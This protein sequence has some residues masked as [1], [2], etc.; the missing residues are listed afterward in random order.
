MTMASSNTP[1]PVD[2]RFNEYES[3]LKRQ[4]STTSKVWDEMTK[5][6]CENKNELKAQCNHCKTIFSAKSSSGTSHL[7]HHLNRCLKKFDADECRQAISTFLVC[8]K[9][10]FRTVEEPGFRYMMR[11]VS[12]NFKNISRHTAARDVLMYYAKERDHVK[13]EL[14]RASGLIC[15]TSDNWNSEHTNDEYICITAHWVDKDWNLQKRIIRFRAL[16][17][18]YDGLNIADELVL[19]LSQWVIDKKN[20]SITLDNASY[21]DVMVSCLKNYFRAN[22]A[23]LCDGAFFQ[24]RCCAHILNLIIKAGLELANDV[25]G[26][27]RKRFYDATDKSFHL[28]VTKKL[29]QDVCERW[30]S[31]YLMLESSLYYKDVLDYWGQRDKDYQMFSLSNEEWRNIAILCKFLKVFYDVTCIFSGSNYPKGNLYFKGVRKVHKV[32]LDTVK[33]P[34][35]FLTPMVKQMQEKFNKYWAEYSL[36]LSCAAILDP[37][38]KL[39]YVQYYFKTI[40]GIHASDFVETILSNLRLLFDE[41]VKKSK[42]TSSSLAES[43]NVSDKNPVDSGLD[44]HNVNS[45]NFGGYFD[46]SDDYKWYLDESSTRTEKSQLDI[47]L[48]EPELE[49]NSQIDVLDYWSKSLVRYNELSLL[50]RDLLAIPISNV[51]SESAFSMDK[52]VITPLKSSL[53]PKTVQAVVCLDDWMRAKGFSTTN[54]Y[55]HFIVKLVAKRTIRTMR[56][57]RMMF[58]RLLFRIFP[59]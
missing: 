3:A 43:S 54:Y 41:Y 20:F 16:F 45:A 22:R 56:T 24:I 55:S 27:R 46:E 14:A 31:T 58:L 29:R 4:K 7:R 38:Y 28:N 12:P 23:I 17:P 6:D 42:S 59:F 37:H 2:D 57:I 49:L 19:C 5:L 35:S 26:I 30:N 50:A 10:S 53:T 39:N 8:G 40:Y 1:I 11:I 51:A 48:E 34:Y 18:P 32:L 15:L 47:Y 13:E 36:I 21:N 33:G 44:E 52:K 9:H 25:V